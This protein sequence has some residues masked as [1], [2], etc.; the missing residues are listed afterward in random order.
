MKNPS[1]E[2]IILL[3]LTTLRVPCWVH[4]C[5]NR[6]FELRKIILL[7]AQM[8]LN[9]LHLWVVTSGDKKICFQIFKS[10][11]KNVL[12]RT[13]PQQPECHRIHNVWCYMARMGR[14][15]K[16]SSWFTCLLSVHISMNLWFFYQNFQIQKVAGILFLVVLWFIKFYGGVICNAYYALMKLK[17]WSNCEWLPV[18]MIKI[19]SMN[20]LHVCKNFFRFL[21]YFD[22]KIF[23]SFPMK[24]SA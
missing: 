21:G 18:Q 5:R 2:T 9:S 7:S 1:F 10:F 24:I 23:S 17:N 12:P 8:D 16:Q 20:R 11:F 22:S 3:S 13:Y 6:T 19:S 4:Y 14:A 15:G